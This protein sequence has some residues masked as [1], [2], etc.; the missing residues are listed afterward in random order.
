LKATDTIRV[1]LAVGSS[2]EAGWLPG[3]FED[4]DSIEIVGV[5]ENAREVLQGARERDPHVL[6]LS[7]D[8]PDIE[9]L[10][11]L[12]QLRRLPQLRTVLLIGDV[13]PEVLTSAVSLGAAAAL[14]SAVGPEVLSRC[15]RSVVDGEYWFGRDLTR[16]FV[17]SIAD[18]QSRPSPVA[19]TYSRLT[20][21]E[22]DV[23][24]AAARGK[25][26]REIAREL[27]LSE[28]TVKQHLKQ[29][30]GK[31]EV[32][33]RVELVLRVARSGR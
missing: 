4:K 10:F 26:N 1:L 33:S 19:D 27:K 20:P 30:F 8:L 14:D 2:R 31:L 24:Q 7:W 5:L 3:A 21:R 13:E 29:V 12:R 22:T 16:T 15:I 9:P 6:V 23:M 28:H 11:L 17:E 18:G 32:S 25:T